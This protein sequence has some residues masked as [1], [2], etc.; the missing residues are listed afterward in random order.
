MRWTGLTD[1]I[2]NLDD[3]ISQLRYVARDREIAAMREAG[4]A[5]ERMRLFR[6]FWDRRDPSPGTRRNERME[7]YYYRV[8]G[9]NALWNQGSYDLAYTSLK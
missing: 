5:Q 4:S 2:A 1:Q 9:V 8:A 6:E 7:E 3:A